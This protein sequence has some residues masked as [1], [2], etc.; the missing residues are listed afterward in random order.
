MNTQIFGLILGV[1]L[2]I[3]M[4]FLVGLPT[5]MTRSTG[6]TGNDPTRLATERID[7][8]ESDDI[9]PDEEVAQAP[10]TSINRQLSEKQQFDGRMSDFDSIV[11][12][13]LVSDLSGDPID[14]VVVSD[15]SNFVHVRTDDRGYYRIE[16]KLPRYKTPFLNFLR[17]GY[18]ENRIGIPMDR[19]S[20]EGEVEVNLSLSP[21]NV[22]T[23]VYGW[24]GNES[25]Q[26]LANQAIELRA[27]SLQ[28]TKAVFYAI[29]SD[30]HGN[31]RFEGIR[32]DIDYRLDI[33]PTDEYAGFSLEPLKVSSDSPRLV[34]VL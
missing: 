14:E 34:L 10:G 18:Q 12:S 17:S 25:G 24:V 15:E 9:A 16:I 1:L 26:G 31:F 7:A 8:V 11:V 30:E 13:G 19:L 27:S 4:V 3:L 29:I 22:S 21:S 20:A 6:E 2:V 33:Q 23:T 32:A 5:G 28:S